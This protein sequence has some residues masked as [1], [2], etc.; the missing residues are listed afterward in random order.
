MSKHSDAKTINDLELGFRRALPGFDRG[1][2][3]EK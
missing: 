1:Y 3:D 2:V